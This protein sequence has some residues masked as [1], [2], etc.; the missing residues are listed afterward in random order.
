M[1]FSQ[2]AHSSLKPLD[3]SPGC[4]RPE[5]WFLITTT[6]WYSSLN[7]NRAPLLEIRAEGLAGSGICF[8]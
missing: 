5:F 4:V 3:V 8:S 1:N 6:Q 7:N 2:E